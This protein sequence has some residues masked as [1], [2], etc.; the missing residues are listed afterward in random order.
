[1]RELV[2]SSQRGKH[3]FRCGWVTYC[4]DEVEAVMRVM[5]CD[6]N[7]DRI[8]KMAD[9]DVSSGYYSTAASSGYGSKAASSGGYAGIAASIGNRGTVRAGENGLLICT[10]WDD[11]AKRYRACVGE[12]GIDGIEADT[13]YRVEDGKLVK[14]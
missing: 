2:E 13:D 7:F 14:V 12:V 8:A 5:C 9:G 4:G 10:Y 11:D 3:R 1:M 6:A